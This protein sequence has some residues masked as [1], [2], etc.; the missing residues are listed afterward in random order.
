[1]PVNFMNVFDP[2]SIAI[3]F[4]GTL[5][6]ALLRCGWRDCAEAVQAIGPLFG[7]PFDSLRVRA[8]LAAQI[9]EI[10]EVGLIG[11][12]PH[13]VGDGEFDE[14]SDTLVRRRSIRALY[15]KHER[16]RA[17]RAALGETARAVLTE[18]ADLA[19]I[20]GLTGTI[21]SLAGMSTATVDQDYGQAIGMAVTSTFY[22]L[23]AANF[24][25]APLAGALARRARAEEQAR[26]ELLDWL[27]EAVERA[28]PTR[29]KPSQPK[30]AA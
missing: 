1:M 19:P 3:V 21:L 18:A 26:Q 4:G 15:D 9:R 30:V 8:E 23:V 10:G 13:R 17:R 7:R 2:L 27:T 24:I 25:F 5:A 28:A 20:L 14:L 29:R 6:A 11:V 22:G 12:E 16:H